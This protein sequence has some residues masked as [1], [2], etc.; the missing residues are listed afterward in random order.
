MKNVL[1]A[2]KRAQ[3]RIEDPKK[4]KSNPAFK[5]AKYVDLNSVLAVIAEPL[6]S[7]GLVVTQTIEASPTGADKYAHYLRTTLWHAESGESIQSDFPLPDSVTAQ[8]LGSA[9]TYARRYSL[10]AMFVLGA[11]DDDG[12][13]ASNNDRAAFLAKMNTAKAGAAKPTPADK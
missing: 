11:E 10:M 5:G 12:N 13:A 3:A 4:S 9:I 7:E 2:L 6:D 1:Q 8:A